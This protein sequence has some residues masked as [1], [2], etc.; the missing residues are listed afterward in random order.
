[1]RKSTRL[2]FLLLAL[3]LLLSLLLPSVALASPSDLAAF[4]DA[5]CTQFVVGQDSNA[6]EHA[7]SDFPGA[8]QISEEYLNRLLRRCSFS[9]QMQVLTTLG[10]PWTGSCYG[11][12]ATMVLNKL[13]Q[14]DPQAEENGYALHI[15]RFQPGA[16]NYFDLTTPK[17]NPPVLDMINYYMGSQNMH[18]TLDKAINVNLYDSSILDGPEKNKA[19]QNLD[20]F[21]EAAKA[22]IEGGKPALFSYFYPAGGHAIVLCDYSETVLP[23]SIVFKLYDENDRTY[24]KAFN[25][26]RYCYLQIEKDLAGNYI[27]QNDHVTLHCFDYLAYVNS[28]R[29]N[30]TPRVEV[31]KDHP[32]SSFRLANIAETNKTLNI[33]HADAPA[34]ISTAPQFLFQDIQ[35]SYNNY[36]LKPFIKS[37]GDIMGG[38]TY[39]DVTGRFYFSNSVAG[40]PI[41]VDAQS[42]PLSYYGNMENFRYSARSSLQADGTEARVLD[43]TIEHTTAGMVEAHPNTPFEGYDVVTSCGSFADFLMSKDSD[44]DTGAFS[45]VSGTSIGIVRFDA[46]GRLCGLLPTCSA[47]ASDV[48]LYCG[49]YGRDVALDMFALYGMSDFQ[50]LSISYDDPGSI[51]LHFDKFPDQIRMQFFNGTLV[52]PAGLRIKSDDRAHD[53]WLKLGTEIVNGVIE[54]SGWT[55]KTLDANGK[56]QFAHAPDFTTKLQKRD[57][58]TSSGGSG[59]NAVEGAYSQFSILE[60]EDGTWSGGDYTLR[61]NAPLKDYISVSVDNVPVPKDGAVVTEGST[62]VTLKAAYLATL[63]PGTHVLRVQFKSGYAQTTL[64]IGGASGVTSAVP[65]V[66][67]TGSGA[68]ALLPALL[69]VLAAPLTGAWRKRRIK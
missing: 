8:Y 36:L 35:S 64:A 59:L 23:N 57:Y 69:G 24:D 45:Y 28:V 60:G 19:D 13:T 42:S 38:V 50:S 56:P 29:N 4:M 61:V 30:V 47:K 17:D 31:F 6:Y 11:I 54:V 62:V 67:A 65:S 44:P 14:L 37:D 49:S 39:A 40:V 7:Y 52:S 15:D 5:E 9:E 68:N 51:L 2:F 32:L 26:T 12:A 43:M 20:D 53:R 48:S 46:G 10:L 58:S 66:P 63:T 1:M 18:A 22:Y 21:I 27:A 25:K 55:A 41:P 16:Q 33:H 34:L 3:S